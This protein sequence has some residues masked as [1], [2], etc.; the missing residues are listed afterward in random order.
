MTIEA[1]MSP[2]IKPPVVIHPVPAVYESICLSNE[3]LGTEVLEPFFLISAVSSLHHRELSPSYK[4]ISLPI[5]KARQCKPLKKKGSR[6][7]HF[8]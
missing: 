7:I 2:S 6:M 1:K 8:I 5:W 3:L 4:V